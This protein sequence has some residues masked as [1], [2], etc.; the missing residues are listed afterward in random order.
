MIRVRKKNEAHL[1]IDSEDSGILMELSEAFTFYAEG[2]KFTPAYKNKWWDGKIRL[3][4][5]LS[6]ETEG[7]CFFFG[8]S[9]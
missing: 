9:I 3:Y 5:T 4:D 2:Y 7:V 1:V 8:G 6:C